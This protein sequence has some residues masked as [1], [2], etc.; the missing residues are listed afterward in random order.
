MCADERREP[1]ARVIAAEPAAGGSTADVVLISMPFGPVLTPSIALGL[2]KA[3]L[4]P[5]GISTKT[6]YFSLWFAEHIGT[7]R[8]RMAAHSTASGTLAGEWIFASAL[9]P[10]VRPD[11]E[12]YLHGVLEAPQSV[13]ASKVP[14]GRPDA[15]AELRDLLEVRGKVD[16]FLDDCLERVIDCRPRIVGFTSVF[17]Q[18]VASLALAKRLKAR[19]PDIFILIGGANCEGVMG[20][21]V[22]RQFPF[23]D[24]VV[25]GEGD[26]VFADLVER[27][28]A[29]DAAIEMPGVYTQGG[30]LFVSPGDRYAWAPVVRDMDA[31][32][33]PDYDEFFEQWE[34]AHL[35]ERER[36]TIQFETSRGCWW[37]ERHHC[38]FCGLN[39]ATMTYR[40]KSSQR[41]L[42]ELVALT[43]RYPGH[44]IGVV[45]NILD[46]R[47]FKEFMPALAARRLDLELFYE[48]K[49]NLKKA[50]VRLLR[51]AGVR[52]IQPG[53]ESFSTRVLDIMRKGERGLHNIQLLKWCK[54]LGVTPVWNLLWGFPG[55][56]PEEYHAMADLLPLLTH[57]APPI[58]AMPIRLDR[59]SPNFDQAEALGF[60]A[61]EPFPAYRYIYPFQPEAVA[62]LAYYFSY[63]YRAPQDVESYTRAVE[64]QVHAWRVACGESDLFSIDLGTLLLICDLRPMTGDR[65][66]A[67]TGLQRALYLACDGARSLSALQAVAHE[68]T[69]SNATTDVDALLQPLLADG[70]MVREGH[71]YLSLAVPVGEY[72]P[73]DAARQRFRAL[74]DR[75]APIARDRT[76]C[77][78]RE[79][80]AFQ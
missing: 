1:A 5:R 62:N 79:V 49:A 50:Q 23:V 30:R 37:G 77:E 65:L 24:A 61:V 27:I 57:L 53:I 8:Y 69:A 17:L 71:S 70:L 31:L 2:L 73:S 44:P 32:P 28:L 64:E 34:S 15:A 51:D 6:L 75:R 10:D 68:S 39:G 18:H 42:D 48:V 78:E 20:A 41:A 55:E 72:S 25:S 74:L 13:F 67:L 63:S 9:F 58:S 35:D 12:G 4:A 33:M 46:H 19:A 26:L 29:G 36:T 59:F 76:G 22:I 56:P 66:T 80:V 7:R 3:S 16:R 11:T 40:S 43:D 14:G 54:E 52:V 60:T 47:Y 38:T 45:D 21:E